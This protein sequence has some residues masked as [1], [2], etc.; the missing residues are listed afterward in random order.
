M[1]ILITLLFV[2]I[3]FGIMLLNLVSTFNTP[4]QNIWREV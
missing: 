3:N 2:D 4:F 1:S